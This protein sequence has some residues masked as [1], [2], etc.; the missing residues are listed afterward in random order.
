VQAQTGFYLEKVE[1]KWIFPDFKRLRIDNSRGVIKL[2]R[3][4]TWTG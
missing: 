1:N 4:T 2:D 3:T